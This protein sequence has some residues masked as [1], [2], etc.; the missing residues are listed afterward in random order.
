MS[1]MVLIILS[2]V[3]FY[4]RWPGKSLINSPGFSNLTHF[5]AGKWHMFSEHF[6]WIMLG[7][8]CLN[9]NWYSSCLQIPGSVV[10][11]LQYH[12]RLLQL[13]IGKVTSLLACLWLYERSYHKVS[14]Q[15]GERIC[16]SVFQR[17]P[18]LPCTRAV[19]VQFHLLV[20]MASN[21][22]WPPKMLLCV[23]KCL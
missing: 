11:I 8:Q 13:G 10:S 15:W 9:L 22:L 14:V 5:S 19:L 2:I 7:W 17:Y 21:G 12:H 6:F 23:W 20:N 3:S 16:I 18:R 4:C 1:L